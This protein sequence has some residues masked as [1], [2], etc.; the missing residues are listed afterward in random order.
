MVSV[1]QV[2]RRASR[3]N[4]ILITIKESTRLTTETTLESTSMAISSQPSPFTNQYDSTTVV[5]GMSGFITMEATCR[6]I[7]LRA[8]SQ[9]HLR[10]FTLS[11]LGRSSEQI[12]DLL[13]LLRLAAMDTRRTILFSGCIKKL[14]LN[15]ILMLR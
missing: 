13:A 1:M 4:L 9:Q 2:F 8:Q 14:A 11:T 15:L 10:F 5:F 6:C 7:G 3:L 12:A